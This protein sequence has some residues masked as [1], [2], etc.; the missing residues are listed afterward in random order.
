VY[1]EVKYI[2]FIKILYA[3]EGSKYE[4]KAVEWMRMQMAMKLI[5]C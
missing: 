4:R 5:L 1:I 3:K 2:I